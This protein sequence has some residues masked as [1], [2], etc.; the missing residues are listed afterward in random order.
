MN[1]YY[2][3]AM[4]FIKMPHIK[5]FVLTLLVCT[6]GLASA[7]I[8]ATPGSCLSNDEF[9]LLNLVNQY[10]ADNGKGAVAYSKILN[11]VGQ[12][13]AEDALINGGSLFTPSCNLHSWS[14]DMPHLWTGMCYTSDHAQAQKMWDKP[15]E[16]SGGSYTGNGYENAAWGYATPAAAL[17]G[18]KNSSGH[19]DV[20]LN[21][22]IW[23][24]ITWRAMGVGVR[25]SY[26][27]LWFSDMTDSST[28]MSLCDDVIFS[29]G[30]E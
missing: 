7:Q 24:S 28:P 17:D 1:A 2:N 12:W 15:R 6:A 18:W 23:S 14:N 27:Y 10:R 21:Q 9:T 4:T 26:Y 5:R 20:M 25:G 19:N 22:G 11:T 30:F 16:I 3:D 29:D 8:P 13:H